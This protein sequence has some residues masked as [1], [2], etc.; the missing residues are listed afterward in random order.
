MMRGLP[1]RQRRATE[2]TGCNKNHQTRQAAHHRRL[3]AALP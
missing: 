1:L 3:K 2:Q